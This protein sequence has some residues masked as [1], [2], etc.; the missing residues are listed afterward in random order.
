MML[1]RRAS[2]LEVT[3]VC[4]TE[5]QLFWDA[6]FSMRYKGIFLKVGWIESRIPATPKEKE[7]K[8]LWMIGTP[9]YFFYIQIGVK[10]AIFLILHRSFTKL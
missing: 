4:D 10:D 9:M 3:E 7:L 6:I 8:N 5:L 1:L 2:Y